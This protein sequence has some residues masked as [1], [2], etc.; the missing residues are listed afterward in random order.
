MTLAQKNPKRKAE[1]EEQISELLSS[2]FKHGGAWVIDEADRLKLNHDAMKFHEDL[3]TLGLKKKARLLLA[4]QMAYDNN[5]I[6]FNVLELKNSFRESDGNIP[7]IGVVEIHNARKATGVKKVEKPAEY[8]DS[9]LSMLVKG[10]SL[11]EDKADDVK[12]I[13]RETLERYEEKKSRISYSCIYLSAAAVYHAA[14]KAGNPL[15]FPQ[16]GEI[17]GKNRNPLSAITTQL[18]QLTRPEE[19][20]AWRVRFGMSS[21]MQ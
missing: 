10:G 9:I 3:E 16:M 7:G 20:D 4:L 1:V 21:A 6:P 15:T 11:D 18:V 5:R 8:L 14:F 13:A 2:H 17:T 19:F 12:R